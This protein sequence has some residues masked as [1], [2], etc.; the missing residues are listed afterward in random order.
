MTS[1]E[2]DRAVDRLNVALAEQ[3]RLGNAYEAAIGTPS[4]FGAYTRLG[5]AGEEVAARQA[6][7]ESIDDDGVG[8]RIWVNG[9]EVGG[10]DSLFQG[11]EDSH[12]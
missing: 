5:S 9:R 2:R 4:E 10:P 7:L 1:D 6:W 12:D 3:D 8:S 11:L